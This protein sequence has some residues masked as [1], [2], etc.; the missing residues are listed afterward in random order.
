VRKQRSEAKQALKVPIS[1]VSISA[2]PSAIGLMP[3]VEADLKSALRVQRF[4]MS[5]GASRRIVVDGYEA[6]PASS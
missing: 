1:R 3:A 5:E 2:E 4:A 6:A